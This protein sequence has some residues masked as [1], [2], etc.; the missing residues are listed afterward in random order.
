MIAA[1]VDV[2]W[3]GTMTVSVA[4]QDILRVKELKELAEMLSTTHAGSVVQL[5][6]HAIDTPAS[7]SSGVLILCVFIST[8]LLVCCSKKI[9]CSSSELFELWCR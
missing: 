6:K 3:D 2:L 9:I 1:A 8:A 5:G 7:S 4:V